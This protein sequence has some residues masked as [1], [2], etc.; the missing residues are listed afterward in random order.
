MRTRRAFTLVEMVVV[1]GIIVV[2]AALTFAV[3]VAVV[4]NSEVRQT[5]ATIKLLDAAVREWE[6]QSDRKVSYGR[7]SNAPTVAVYDIQQPDPEVPDD[8]R[9]ITDELFAIIGRSAQVEEILA[10][11][12]PQFLKRE[13]VDVN[14]QPIDRLRFYDPWGKPIVA[15][16]PGRPWV[17]ADTYDRDADGTIRTDIERVC[18]RTAN[19]Q[20]CFVSPGP[21]G[22][23]GDLSADEDSAEYALTKD[24]IYSYLADPQPQ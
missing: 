15:I 9:T 14:G 24:N 20:I 22:E 21:D 6:S 16:M 5:E 13:Q 3:G 11:V 12:D 4:Q 7:D 2:L 17:T 23:V 8:A 19:R 18:G 1:I 10:K